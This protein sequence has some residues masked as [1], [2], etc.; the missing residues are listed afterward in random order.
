MTTDANSELHY[1]IIEALI[2]VYIIIISHFNFNDVVHNSFKIKSFL[3]HTVL[4]QLSRTNL[5]IF[6]YVILVI[7][8][9]M[10]NS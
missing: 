6:D 3:W 9:I 1:V 4:K 8:V 10:F 5:T 2:L 7:D